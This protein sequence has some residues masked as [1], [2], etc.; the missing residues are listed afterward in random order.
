MSG[1]QQ[2]WRRLKLPRQIHDARSGLSA[3]VC[4]MDRCMR[5]LRE[6]KRQGGSLPQECRW[7]VTS[8]YTFKARHAALQTQVLFSQQSVEC[9][10]VRKMRTD[11]GGTG[12]NVLAYCCHLT[13]H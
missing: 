6:C 11:R 1:A 2:A 7:M 3:A 5:A 13:A 9:C 4:A 10:E 12:E 8:C